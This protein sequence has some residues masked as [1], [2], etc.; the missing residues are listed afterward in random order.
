MINCLL[1]DNALINVIFR[2]DKYK[3]IPKQLNRT[4]KKDYFLLLFR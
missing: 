3:L 2:K 4:I 1:I